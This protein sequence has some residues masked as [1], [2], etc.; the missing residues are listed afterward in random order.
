MK[1]SRKG[2][3]AESVASRVERLLDADAWYSK[4]VDSGIANLSAIADQLSEKLSCSREAA[5][6]AVA[7][8][9][10]KR[11][12]SSRGGPDRVRGV[13]AHSTVSLQDGIAVIVA[14]T[15]PQAR[16]AVHLLEDADVK[17]V[18][19]G[20]R[21]ITVICASSDCA[22]VVHAFGGHVLIE[23]KGLCLIQLSSKEDI[24]SVPGVY[25]SVLD[26]FARRGIN[27]V[28]SSSCYT[29]TNLIVRQED[30]VA[31]FEAM[32]SACGKS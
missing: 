18:V 3:P 19:V 8:W 26:A 15:S 21:S 12:A 6:V 25:A 16:K 2:A 32:Q 13:L 22:K 1:L 5:K 23:Q 20:S 28:E 31:G 11:V 29:E 14:E 27:V 7:R 9:A 24:E 30:A 4:A 17:S 10:R